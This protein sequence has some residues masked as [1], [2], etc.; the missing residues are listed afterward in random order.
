M[1]RSLLALLLLLAG[2]VQ[3][4]AQDDEDLR[5]FL[6]FVPNIQFAPLY[7]LDAE[8][9][10]TGYTLEFQYGDEPIGVDLIAAGEID[11]G[12]ISGEQI[13]LARSGERP[14]V[15]FYEWYQQY[16]VGIVIPDTTAAETVTDLV[17]QR[18][19]IPGRFG[20]S[21]S[22]L[23]ALLQFNGLEESDI[24]LEPI[25]F[26]AP[27]V[28]CNAGGD[29]VAAAVVYISNEPLQIE[30][31]AAA[32]ECGDIQ[33]ARVIPVAEYADMVSNGLAASEDTISNRP[34][35]V[36]AMTLAFDT[37]LQQVINNPAHAYLTSEPYIE[38]LPL[39]DE[40]RAALESAAEQ[41][42]VFLSD[43]PDREAVAASREALLA[44]LEAQF[45]PEQ[46]TQLRVLLASI[47]LWDADQLGYTDAGSW[48]V[49]LDILRSLDLLV[50]DDVDLHSA[51]TNDFLPE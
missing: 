36:R 18:V 47:N 19:G 37:A 42:E 30:Q 40:L 10:L 2:S 13:I 43:N 15:Y 33:S 35:Q 28:I 5:F 29:G 25:G 44:E 11:F 17:G 6:S 46:L 41:Q 39:D 9:L 14:V 50:N 45:A 49:T 23:T 38:N 16:P 3:N 26:N 34:E 1:R 7:V 20:A 12:V 27:D 4:N 31:R 8:N 32:G 21:Y 24:R 48:T 51:F 22:G